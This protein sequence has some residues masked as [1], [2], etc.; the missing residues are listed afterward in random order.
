MRP[1]WCTRISL[2]RR[3]RVDE[4]NPAVPSPIADIVDRLLAK[5]A[6]HRY[7]SA[8]G[9]GYDLEQCLASL[10]GGRIE[11]FPLG[12]RDASSRLRFPPT[13]YGREHERTALL[14]AFG[15]V[16]AGSREL[17]LVAGDPGVG[18]SSLVHEVDRP[19]AERGGL[20][21]EGK[22]DQLQRSLP[23]SALA[24]AFRQLVDK[25]LT[26]PDDAFA[27]WRDGVVGA[28][29]AAS[30]ALR[31][32]V[33]TLDRLVGPLP[34]LAEAG[35]AEVQN[36][37]RVATQALVRTLSPPE[38]P[39]VLF[40]D[41]LQWADLAS[42]D[43]LRWIL[44]DP[45]GGRVLVIGAYRSNEVPAGHGLHEL[46]QATRNAHVPTHTLRLDDLA[47][48][49][50]RS[51]L[52]DTLHTA[53]GEGDELATLVHAKTRGNPFFVRRFVQ[54]LDDDG[55]LR[56]DGDS[57][58]WRWDSGAIAALDITDNV[59]AF[60]AA[61]LERL[62][63]ATRATVQ[64]AACIGGRF[65]LSTLSAATGLPSEELHRRLWPAVSTG[66]LAPVGL[67]ARLATGGEDAAEGEEAD[68]AS[69]SYAFVHDRVRQAAYEA[70][71]PA[72]RTSAHLDIGRSLL[73][74][75]SPG[76][77]DARLFEIVN[78]FDVAAALVVEPD[79]RRTL[80]RLNLAAG[81]R[82][83]A[84]AAYQPARQYL[85][86]GLSLLGEQA[87]S[88]EY[89]LVLALQS[90]QAEASYLAG[91]LDD[92]DRA[93]ED[94]MGHARTALDSVSA[95][96]TRVMV[97]YARDRQD[98]VLEHGLEALRRLGV[99]F[100]SSPT[101]AS[102][103]IDLARTK[104]A[105]RGRP[106]ESLAELPVMTDAA[107]IAAMEMIGRMI[108]AAFRSGSKIFPLLVFRL[109]RLSARHGNSPDSSF[110]Y[111]TY[112]I[113]LCGVLGDYDAGYRFALVGQRV[114]ERFN[115][116]VF[117][118]KTLFVFGNFVRHWKEPLAECI[119]PLA[120]SWRFGIES[121][122]RFEAVWATFYRLLWLLQ[123][124]R[125][126]S[127]VETGVVAMEGLLAEDVG[128]AAA[129]KLLRQAVA[130][131]AGAGA[132]DA[133]PARLAGP[134]YDEATMH[135][136]HA[137]ATDQTHLCF[138]HAI[139]LQLAVWFGDVGRGAPS[140]RRGRTA[141]RGGD[142]NAVRADHS[143]LRRAG[144]PRRAGRAFRRFVARAAGGETVSHAGAL[145]PPV[146]GQLYA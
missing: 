63:D 80:A 38:R 69:W 77:E 106:I 68:V 118:S 1:N 114:A 24:E 120:Q 119:E 130:N 29:G 99:R 26:E 116:P 97:A 64:T 48:A 90:E 95:R 136:L 142:V 30:G 14:D 70:L 37:F 62:P 39:L 83:A 36:R 58:R 85:S 72:A 96:A 21:M 104:L 86:A 79:E 132:R 73:A 51:L 137:T 145:G 113:S 32:L 35:S 47:L 3:L 133:S 82:A 111:S 92:A 76:G 100:P 93:T 74:R 108:P 129:G 49:D 127:E 78:H 123:A 122:A 22:F 140:R 15:R 81:R 33:P 131:L 28:L 102:I 126:L 23:Y 141:D 45:N 134:H 4:L 103:V 31:P 50:V 41:D 57:L 60:V 43:V 40:L 11:P 98:L 27:R 128:A 56:F 107:T 110:G 7:Q 18:K 53:P 59:V 146:A 19:I 71:D 143:V 17:I 10:D 46:L 125:D 34:D 13:L 121:G 44:T 94:V 105:L 139:K 2:A 52:A 117:R 55:Q 88:A 135:A 61:R 138:Y 144:G 75:G 66:L 112:A 124:G 87:W 54:S 12:R 8:R 109:V 5:D 9:L 101:T 25:L 67:S 84:S 6:E 42:L 65:D 89:D 20:F 16:R 91:A 115:A